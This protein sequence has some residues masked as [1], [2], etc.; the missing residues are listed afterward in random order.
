[1]QGAVFNPYRLTLASLSYPAWRHCGIAGLRSGCLALLGHP[2]LAMA[3]FTASCLTDILLQWAV[4]GWTRTAPEEEGVEAPLLVALICGFRSSLYI[5]APMA[6]AL[7]GGGPAEFLFLTLMAC[8]VVAFS[9]SYGAFSQRVFWA[10]ALPVLSALA[11]TAA[12]TLDPLPAAVITVSI[13]ITSLVMTLVWTTWR[14]SMADWRRTHNASLELIADLRAARDRA[15]AERI[16]ADEAREAARRAGEAKSNFLAAMSHEIRTPM[17]GVLGM[18][19]L[20]RLAEKDP[21][22][23]ARLRMLSESGEHLLA[24][25]DD[26]LDMSRVESGRLDLAFEAHDLPRFLEQVAAF[27]AGEAAAKG[28]ELHLDAD[29]GLPRFVTMDAVRVRQVLFNLIG[30]AVKFTDAG[31]V[32]LSARAGAPLEG[33]ARVVLTV[34][35]TGPGV[36]PEMLPRLFERFSQA[37]DAATRRFGGAGLG[38]AICKQMT[39]LMGGRIRVDSRPGEGARFHVELVLALAGREAIQAPDDAPDADGRQLTVLAVDDNPINL[40]VVEQMMALRGHAVVKASDGHEAL[41]IA[42]TQAF[43][44]V[45]MDIHMPGMSGIEVL[46]ALR[47]GTGPNRAAPVVALTADV[48]SGGEDR[49]RALGFSAYTTKPLQP[50]RLFA[51]VEKALAAPPARLAATG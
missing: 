47:A 7:L 51:A 12:V 33:R 48:T 20:L 41:E 36:A 37:E 9:L 17:N 44:L 22:Q 43:D 23:V 26:I 14:D 1:M 5:S 42:A 46:Q 16:A 8:S 21:E 29:P 38:L 39:E 15:L 50:P 24:I 13:V 34:T 25:L 28:L 10:M 11:M 19:E 31:A 4:A 18:A 49:Y 3:W 6:A 2:V 27:W 32:T 30:N 40:Q 35:D 45:L